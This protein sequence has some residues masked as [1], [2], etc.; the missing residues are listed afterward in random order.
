MHMLVVQITS[1]HRNITIRKWF[2]EILKIGSVPISPID[3]QQSFNLPS[4]SKDNNKRDVCCLLH[5][6][7]KFNERKLKEEQ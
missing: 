1:A 4:E 7:I 2:Y 5:K 3:S 6:C